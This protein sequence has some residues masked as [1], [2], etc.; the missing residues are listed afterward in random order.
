MAVEERTA[1]VT[2]AT[3]GLGQ[4]A[5]KGIA[6]AGGWH[7]VLA[8]RDAGRAERTSAG[9]PSAEARA[10]DLASLASVRAFARDLAAAS[11]PP[12]GAIV[13]NAGIQIVSG[14][15]F[16]EDGIET[17]FQVNHLAHFLLVRLLLEQAA[18]PVRVV[19][20]SSGTHDPSRRTGMPK[21]HYTSAEA[22]AHPPRADGEDAGVEGRRRY[23]TAKLCNV[24]CAYEL[25]RRAGEGVTA[26][27][28]SRRAGEGVT[29]NA[30]DPG[31]MPGTGLARDY[32]RIQ[33]A[34]W[35]TVM[36]RLAPILPGLH[37]PARSG[38]ALARLAVDP[39]LE[40]VTG[41]YFEGARA[42]ASS[43]DSYD[44]RK[45]RDLWE[46]SERLVA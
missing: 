38:A 43:T 16:T 36:P 3:G 9:L 23:T 1:I 45:A 41:A 21:P 40:G 12:L 28:L 18:R 10:L 19:F 26:N 13:C 42:A 14:A 8:A 17:T 22:L 46:T 27:A 29:A 39:E 20:V 2:G 4:E 33:R 37:T 11:V 25:S 15:T 7:V 35:T 30:F 32:G 34:A 6:A 44:G 24:L 31:L 5:A